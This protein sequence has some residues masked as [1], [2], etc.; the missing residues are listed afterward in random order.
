MVIP[1]TEKFAQLSAEDYISQFLIRYFRP[2]T[3][4]IGYDHRFGKGRSGNYELLEQQSVI[5][6]FNL[7]EIPV[8]LINAISVSSTRIRESI[9]TGDMETA[10][11][12]LGYN[13]FFSGYVVEGN[14]LGRSIGYP[15]ANLVVS[16]QTKLIPCDG[17]YA[18]D[19]EVSD[20]PGTIYRGMMNI[21]YR[22]R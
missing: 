20:E 15:T 12:L 11:Q 17:V 6:H 1:F 4:I 16:D 18:V 7:M 5:Y 9:G 22:P 3:L 14:R 21:G 8:H 13:F 2:H 19:L 10:R